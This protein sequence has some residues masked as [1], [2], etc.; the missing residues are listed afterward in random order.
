MEQKLKSVIKY[1]LCRI[2]I[3]NHINII[4]ELNM[5]LEEKNGYKYYPKLEKHFLTSLK[6]KYDTYNNFLIKDQNKKVTFSL[7]SKTINN[8]LSTIKFN[9]INLFNNEKHL[10]KYLIIKNLY[11]SPILLPLDFQHNLI[12]YKYNYDK[13]YMRHKFPYFF[14]NNNNPFYD[15]IYII[16]MENPF[17]YYININNKILY[18]TILICCNNKKFNIMFELD[19]HNMY[20]YNLINNY[21][22]I[23]TKEIYSL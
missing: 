20:C 11:N 2:V 15:V 7:L 4:N 16:K 9:T 8:F 1:E 10:F 3:K 6:I 5:I 19:I 17:Y 22:K 23:L 12:K 13:K 21:P 14:D 18:D